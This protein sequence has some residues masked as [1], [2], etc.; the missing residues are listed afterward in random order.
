MQAGCLDDSYTGTVFVEEYVEEGALHEIRM[1]IGGAEQTRGSG[2]IGDVSSFAGKDFYVYAFNRDTKTDYSTV[3][4][5]DSL[6]CLVDGSYDDPESLMGRRAYWNPATEV[7]EWG[8]GESPIYYPMGENEGHDFDFFAYYLDN[9]EPANEDIIRSNDDI[10]INIEI[11]GSQDLMSAKAKPTKAQLEDILDK[12]GEVA[13]LLQR[14]HCYS[15]YTASHNLNPNFDFIH[16]LVK[17]DFKLVPGG[18][19]G[20]TKD[21]TVEKIE[22]RTKHKATFTVA[23]KYDDNRL[24]L[25]F[26]EDTTRLALKERDGSEY[27]P[28]LI[29]TVNKVG[30]VTDGIVDDLGSLLVAPDVE[31]YLYIVLGEVQENGLV[32]ESKENEKV[33]YQGTEEDKI[34]FTSGNEYLITLTIYGQ[35]DVRVNAEIGKWEEGG[36]YEYDY[37]D[38]TRPNQGK[39]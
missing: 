21:V 35:M 7:V 38:T 9:I 37:D 36:D 32:L 22:I 15:Y 4:A 3:S 2:V 19:P 24:G 26:K 16:H 13:M 11:D 12:Q 33:I 29:S 18:T 6:R 8:V 1:T 30:A 31:Y 39:N 17:L 25:K 20:M 27:Q 23:D 34:E 10:K 14:E 5:T 28:R